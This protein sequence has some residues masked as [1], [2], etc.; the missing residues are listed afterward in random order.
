M[1]HIFKDLTMCDECLTAYTTRW[2]FLYKSSVT[3]LYPRKREKSRGRIGLR[4]RPLHRIDVYKRQA[5]A[6]SHGLSS[7][8]HLHSTA[9]KGW[10]QSFIFY[11]WIVFRTR[12]QGRMSLGGGNQVVPPQEGDQAGGHGLVLF[13]GGV[14]V[15]ALVGAAGQGTDVIALLRAAQAVHRVVSLVQVIRC[16]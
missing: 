12:G 4:K 8:G 13:G 2:Q 3:V 6:G 15:A 11:C 14:T 7:G 9:R 1:A 16:V 10:L 5:Q